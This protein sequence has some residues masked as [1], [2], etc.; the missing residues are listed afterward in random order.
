MK[1]LVE[2]WMK[3]SEKEANKSIVCLKDGSN[4][5]ASQHTI[6]AKTLFEC[7]EELKSLLQQNLM[8]EVRDKPLFFERSGG[9]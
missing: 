6:R 5:L 9:Y 4:D 8:K 3:K 1:N 7:A 2:K